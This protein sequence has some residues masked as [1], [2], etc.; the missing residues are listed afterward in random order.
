MRQPC[1]LIVRTEIDFDRPASNVW[2]WLLAMDKWMSGLRFQDI[3]GKAGD[4]GQVRLVTPEGESL[5]RSYFI[6]T[7]CVRPFAQ[8][9]LKVTPERG[10]DYLG[11][12]DF[13]ITERDGRTHMIYDIYLEL[14]VAAASAEELL[15]VRADQYA[16]VRAEALRNNEAL[17][18]L[19]EAH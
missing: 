6:T 15:R 17:K 19:A 11:F 4:E 1:D 3:R 13:S 18:S 2:P 16:S 10:T 12:A 9:V 14:R 8:Y 7:V 5:Y